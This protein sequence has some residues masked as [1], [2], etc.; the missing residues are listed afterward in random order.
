MV[1]WCEDLGN[2]VF[3]FLDRNFFLYGNLLDLGNFVFKFW[4]SNFFLYG[5]LLDLGNFVFKFW[6]RN[7]FLCGKL[8]TELHRFFQGQTMQSK[9]SASTTTKFNS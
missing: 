4:D 9:N 6:D 3:K 8:F 2:F 1:D 5:K 7:F